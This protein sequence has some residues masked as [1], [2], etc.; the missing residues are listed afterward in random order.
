M[1]CDFTN[2]CDTRS[3]SNLLQ[4]FV[5]ENVDL[6][7]EVWLHLHLGVIFGFLELLNIEV[8]HFCV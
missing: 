6:D 1:C 2:I 7:H 3:F 8:G 5:A 4:L